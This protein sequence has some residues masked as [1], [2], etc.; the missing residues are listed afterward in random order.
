[1]Y[2]QW[3]EIFINQEQP[4]IEYLELWALVAGV[5]SWIHRFHNQ[6]VILFCDNMSVVEMINSTSSSCKNS[7]VLI[8]IFVLKTLTEN[9]RVFARH[10][11]SKQ[12]FYSDVLSRL[13]IEKFWRLAE[14]NGKT[15]E[16]TNTEPP[17]EMWPI[18]KIW[19][20]SRIL[21]AR[22]LIFYFLHF[23]R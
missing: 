16:E 4:S 19:I 10:V 21:I 2:S 6:R 3:D 18:N 11:R 9:V 20:T 8:R 15:F 1:M 17:P 23:C 14:E 13:E 12:N 5:V 7:M 22:T